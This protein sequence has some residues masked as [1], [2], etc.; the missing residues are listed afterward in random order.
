MLIIK[1]S[2]QETASGT[3][4]NRKKENMRSDLNVMAVGRNSKLKSNLINTFERSTPIR[5]VIILLSRG[6]EKEVQMV[7]PEEDPS[8]ICSND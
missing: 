5:Y 2:N 1:C 7:E 8:K 6:Q 3:R 4:T